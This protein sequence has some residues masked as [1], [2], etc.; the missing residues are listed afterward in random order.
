[1]ALIASC[2]TR[3]SFRSASRSAA[4]LLSP[5]FVRA[6]GTTPREA[7]AANFPGSFLVLS[8]PSSPV[9]FAL[10]GKEFRPLPYGRNNTGPRSIA[11]LVDVVLTPERQF[12]PT[13]SLQ[14]PFFLPGKSLRIT[15]V[16]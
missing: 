15:A 6:R 14:A 4:S 5:D 2:K 16:R 7:L 1:M 11:I 13:Q 3:N 8:L 9:G 12:I 10:V